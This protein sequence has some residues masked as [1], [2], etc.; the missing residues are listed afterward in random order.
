MVAYI[1]HAQVQ[2]TDRQGVVGAACGHGCH[3]GAGGGRMMCLTTV[4]AL[5]T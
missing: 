2:R 4:Y 1:A 5:V 3:G